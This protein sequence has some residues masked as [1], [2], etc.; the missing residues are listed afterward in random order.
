MKKKKKVLTVR[1][2]KETN[3]TNTTKY[4]Q[5]LSGKTLLVVNTGSVKKKF[6]FQKLKKMGL[7]VIVLHKEKNWAQPYVDDW[8]IAELTNYKE[9]I[10]AVK[11][12]ISN[13]PHIKID[14][15]FTFWEESVLLTSKLV[16]RFNF[17]GIPYTVAKKARNKFNFREFCEENGIRAPRHR[18]I[19]KKEDLLTIEKYL[20]FPVV[21]KP[22]YGSYSAFVIKVE[23][24]EDLLEAY[25]YIKKNISSYVDAAEWDDLGVLV[26]EYIDGDEV[27]ID[28]LLQNGKI[29]FYSISDN[30]NKMKE[31]FFIDSGQAIPSSLPPRD[32]QALLE[33]AEETLEKL[34]VQNGCI[35][36]E[37]K[38]TKDG[39]IPIE[40]NLRMGGDY[41]YSYI[42]GAWNIDLVENAVKIA[43]G[44][45]IKVKPNENPRKYIIGWDLHADYS[46]MVVE[47]DVDERLKHRRYL[48]E[49]HIHKQIGDTILVPPDGFADYMGW[50]T[51]SGDNLLDAQDNLS[52]ILAKIKYKIVKFNSDSS[53]GKTLR[54]SRFSSAVLNKNL[55]MKAAKIEHIKR[56]SKRS[57]KNLHIGIVGG[58]SDGNS[59]N[60]SRKKFIK[61]LDR[62]VEEILK[63][64]GY[65][66]VTLF[67]FS[68]I[69]KT[70]A[71]LRSSDVD[72]VFNLFQREDSSILYDAHVAA[73]LDVLQIPYTGSNLLT[74][75]TCVDKIRVKKIL[76]YHDIPTPRWDYAYSMDDEIDENLEFPLIV[77]PANKDYSIGI[78]QGSVVTNKKELQ[79]QLKKVIE[80][81][82]SPALIEEYISGDEYEVSIM[83]NDNTKD[84]RVLP[85]AR[86][87]FPN[88]R[89]KWNIMDYRSKWSSTGSDHFY[90]QQP[91]KNISK[92]LESLITEIA[93]DTYNI[94]EC[95][96]YGRVEIKID[97]N[98]NPYVLEL[99]P[100]P[101][102]GSDSALYKA[103]QMTG[104]YYGD[105]IEDILMISINRYKNQST[106]GFQPQAVQL[107]SI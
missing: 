100:T 99:N 106:Y 24:K 5:T 71:Q 63:T 2:T 16:D 95:Q 51:V 47:L 83:G 4:T 10:E 41:V 3:H 19:S 26:E 17:I 46:G 25:D 29:K 80:D 58:T 54:R 14:G 93:L 52:E 45:F 8:I 27:D 43:L 40:A 96:D 56:T 13:H 34:G 79:K 87:I 66:K 65:K 31:S 60:G 50:L 84:Q 30:F 36:F 28:I 85:L 18:L 38:T 76:E 44:E 42:K 86:T 33:L 92:R 20:E 35:H 57:L 73:V 91:P 37:A 90:Y 64:R 59:S 105:F 74:L 68:D 55:L 61:T 104:I 67:N 1:Q 97:K 69:N 39:S 7:V 78:T 48:E 53:L 12:Y 102:L 15:V 103:A 81:L 11:S 98:N 6:I 23:N 94:L 88:P 77:K 82:K 70:F 72:L 21:I 32:Q 89:H 9:S 107:T 22:V 49:M 62:E 75:A 101:Q